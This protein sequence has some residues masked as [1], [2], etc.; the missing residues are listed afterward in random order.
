MEIMSSNGPKLVFFSSITLLLF[1]FTFTRS[2]CIDEIRQTYSHIIF[3][4]LTRE[5]KLIAYEVIKD[6]FETQ[7]FMRKI[8]LTRELKLIAYEVIKDRFETQRFMRKIRIQML[9]CF[10]PIFSRITIFA[11]GL[12][13][14][15]SQQCFFVIPVVLNRYKPQI[16]Q[17]LWMNS[18]AFDM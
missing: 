7:R 4:V 2:P 11:Y 17:P 3:F 15:I 16:T 18:L 6:R 1:S 10:Y 12:D 5:L 8:L 14:V 13:L 9:A